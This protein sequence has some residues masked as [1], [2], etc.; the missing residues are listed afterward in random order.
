MKKDQEEQGVN[1]HLKKCFG[2]PKR[3]E[4]ILLKY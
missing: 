2:S 1:L 4:M 3:K